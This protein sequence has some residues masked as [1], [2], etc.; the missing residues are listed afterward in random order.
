M[1][2]DLGRLNRRLARERKAREEAEAIADRR[3]R[4]LWLANRDL[5]ARVAE[6]TAELEAALDQLD[7]STIAA[8]AFL[9]NLSHEMRTPLNGVKGMLELLS[10]SARSDTETSYLEA[11]QQSSERLE[12]LIER[13]LDLVE[14]RSGRVL[15]RPTVT[16][17]EELSQTIVATWKTPLLQARKLLTVRTIASQNIRIDVERVLQ[18]IS[19]LIDNTIVHAN[20][21]VV[22]VEV[23]TT[24]E[25]VECSVVD[26]G[27]GF[28]ATA[29]QDR[30][31]DTLVSI[32]T[33]PGRQ[34]EGA[35]IG[36][37]LARELTRVLG[38][39]ITFDTARGQQSRIRLSLPASKSDPVKPAEFS[40]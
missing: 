34:T 17:A 15:P 10:T 23:A 6:R 21:G 32:D 31:V 7:R 33:S 30:L 22:S 37:G 5:D 3:M 27:P 13:M 35:G 40:A 8:A 38:G 28:D 25:L 11:A 19:E 39:T 16:T 12:K 26:A 14:L 1:T 18:I 36:L 4:E 20:A 2:N 29:Q 9:S 24:A